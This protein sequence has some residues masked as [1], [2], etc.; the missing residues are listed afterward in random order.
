MHQLHGISLSRMFRILTVA[1]WYN[2]HMYQFSDDFVSVLLK[3]LCWTQTKVYGNR[4]NNNRFPAQNLP[5]FVQLNC[6]R[7]LSSFKNFV[8]NERF[9]LR[10]LC[11]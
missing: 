3:K 10:L 4:K 6:S 2:R 1:T 7:G 8:N 5:A 9:L 11:F